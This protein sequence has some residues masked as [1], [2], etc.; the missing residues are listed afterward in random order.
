MLEGVCYSCAALSLVEE[1]IW[2]LNANK[3]VRVTSS[4][5]G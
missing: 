3:F 4:G 1:L 5:F 2:M